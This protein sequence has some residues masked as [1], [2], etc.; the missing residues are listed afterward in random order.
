MR[1]F[2]E[3]SRDLRG[4]VRWYARACLDIDCTGVIVDRNRMQKA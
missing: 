1:I 4:L 3:L 2:E